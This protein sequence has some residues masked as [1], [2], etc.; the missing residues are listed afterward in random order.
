MEEIAPDRE[1]LTQ[2]LERGSSGRK[3]AMDGLLP[4][5]YDKLRSVDGSFR[6]RVH[7]FAVAPRIRRHTLV[8]S[9]PNLKSGRSGGEFAKI[10][11]EDAIMIGPQADRGIIELDDALKPLAA[12]DPRKSG[13]IE[14]LFSSP[15]P[16][17][18]QPSRRRSLPPRCIASS[19]LPKPRSIGI[20][21]GNRLEGE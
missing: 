6:E 1:F 18:R 13:L 3:Q 7:F 19:L 8:D 9:P 16:T 11:P 5:V 2:L 14:L 12:H 17:T 10:P 15:S 4:V 20:L 21:A